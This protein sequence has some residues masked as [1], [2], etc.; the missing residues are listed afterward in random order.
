MGGW[1]FASKRYVG[2]NFKL[3]VVYVVVFAI[4]CNKQTLK[5]IIFK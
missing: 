1:G 2:G 5:Q 4:G 3:Q